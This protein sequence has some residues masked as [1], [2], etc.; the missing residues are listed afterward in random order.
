M[1]ADDYARRIN[2]NN[3]ES[4]S[5]AAGREV[6]LRLAELI[7]DRQS[8]NYETTLSSRQ[9]VDLMDRARK[10]GFRVGLV[11]V[12]L[13]SADLHIARV[14]TRVASGGH[15]IPADTILR[16][17]ERSL[18]HL[19]AAIK[20]SDEIIIFDNT[21]GQPVTLCRLDRQSIVH[22]RLDEADLFHVRIADLV[23]DGLGIS[24]DAV[25]RAAKHGS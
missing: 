2:P 16:R 18:A 21:A 7:R 5:S 10:A 4:V 19:P 24:T 14:L 9:S 22:N 25:F 17:Y 8:F 20:L 15:D 6:L 23:G 1:N 13:R 12:Y 3:P 11:F